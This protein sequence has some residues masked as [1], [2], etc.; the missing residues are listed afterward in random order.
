MIEWVT[1]DNIA[2][3]AGIID[4]I[5]TEAVNVTLWDWKF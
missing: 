4:A 2:I 3:L 1:W 5:K